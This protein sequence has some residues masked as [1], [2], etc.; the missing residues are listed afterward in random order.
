[1]PE[2]T[3]SLEAVQVAERG[4]ALPEPRDGSFRCSPS[5]AVHAR[6]TRLRRFG[7]SHAAFIESGV[8]TRYINLKKD[9]QRPS[10]RTAVS[11]AAFRQH[12]MSSRTSISQYKSAKRLPNASTVVCSVT[13]NAYP[14]PG[15]RTPKV[16][17]GAKK[18]V[19]RLFTWRS[20]AHA[21]LLV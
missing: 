4:E 14:R 21:E 6:S 9:F 20:E 2:R 13:C 12:A 10:W 5:Q 15:I 3:E 7:D 17:R 11:R 18:E 8:S 19:K 1:M 16:L